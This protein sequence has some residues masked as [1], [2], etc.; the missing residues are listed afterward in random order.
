M[1]VAHKI[2]SVALVSIVILLLAACS[3]QIKKPVADPDIARAAALMANGDYLQAAQIYQGLAQRILTADRNQYL[4]AAA[5]AYLQARDYDNA[6]RII[7]HLEQQALSGEQALLQQLMQVELLLAENQG[8]AALERLAIPPAADS[9]RT[10]RQRFHKDKATA[11][12]Q[13]GNLLQTADQLIALDPLLHDQQQRLDNQTEI[14]RT[15]AL[16]NEPDLVSQQPS[17]PGITRGWMQ[18]ALLV[19]QHG[20]TPEALAEPLQQWRR[21]FPTHPALPELLDNYLAKLQ[22]QVFSATRIAILLPEQGPYAKAAAALRDGIV[23]GH[24]QQPAD[25][26]PSLRFYDSTDADAIWPLYNQAVTEG[27]EMVIGPLQKGAVSQLLNAGELPVPVLALNQVPIATAPPTHLFMYSLSPEDE[28]RQAAERIW[29]DERRSPLILTPR[30]AWGERLSHAFEQRWTQLGGDVAGA[31]AYDSKGH[32]YSAAIKSLLHIDK[33]LARRQELQKWIGKKL[34]FEPRR[35]QDVDAIFLAAR[36]RQAQSIPPQLQ[37]FQADDLPIYATSHAWTGKLTAQQLADMK[38]LMLTEIPWLASNN[39]AGTYNRQQTS[40]HLPAASSTYGRLYAMGMDSYRLAPHLK[41]LQSSPYE[42]LDGSTGNLYM[43]AHNQLH[44]Q[45]V[46]LKLDSEPQIIGYSP[47]MDLG[48]HGQLE[49]IDS[50]EVHAEPAAPAA[51]PTPA[52]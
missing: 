11:Y 33:S 29:L 39:S 3:P 2:Q 16:L 8:M 48:S 27:A 14:L 50:E 37:F 38:G 25:K 52:N 36:P 35:R 30:G 7:A 32:D 22:L 44:R 34:E 21:Q 10:L 31:H 20:S 4:Q 47:R 51:A 19:K 46:W 17:P 23:L 42:S 1:Q 40:A 6:R 26:R 18:L 15:L 12:R 43:D 28:A 24:L 13:T 41:R 5:D 45:M 49:D 9:S